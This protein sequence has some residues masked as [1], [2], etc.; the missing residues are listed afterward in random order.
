MNLINPTAEIYIPSGEPAARALSRTTHLCIAAHQDDIEIMAYNAVAECYDDPQKAFCGVV[1]TDG[2]GSPRAGLYAD[3]TDLQM[4]QVRAAEQKQAAD[5]GRYAAQLLLGYP[6]GAV[7]DG[8]NAEVSAE[9]AQIIA[10]TRPRIIFTHNLFDKHD[11]HVAVALR[12][13]SAVR[14]L[15][16]EHR[17]EKIY[18][19]E[20]WRGLDWLTD[21]SKIVFD[22]GGHPNLAAALMGIFD[23]QIAGGKRYDLAALGRRTANATFLASHNTDNLESAAYGLDITGLCLDP[24]ADIGGFIAG[25]I[26]DFASDVN[27]RIAGLKG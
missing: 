6:S 27:N 14:S 24:A 17:P 19:M 3:F 23:S 21:D 26:A 1:V 11:T 9:L 4:R 5:I 15:A 13:I 18:S 8:G 7:K 20:V 2:A 25:H 10:A 22:T 16:P 12:V